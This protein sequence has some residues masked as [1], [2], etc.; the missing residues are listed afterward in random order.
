MSLISLLTL[1]FNARHFSSLDRTRRYVHLRLFMTHCSFAQVHYWTVVH[2]VGLWVRVSV[3]FALW[4]SARS[5][6][7]KAVNIS[8]RQSQGRFAFLYDWSTSNFRNWSLWSVYISTQWQPEELHTTI[9]WL[10]CSIK[11]SS[12][13]SAQFGA[14]VYCKCNFQPFPAVVAIDIS[15]KLSHNE[16]K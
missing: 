6:K 15:I 12:S 13:F 2:N 3:R 9:T 16:Q 8:L 4:K 11:S 14:P 10:R 5:V 1:E 7:Y